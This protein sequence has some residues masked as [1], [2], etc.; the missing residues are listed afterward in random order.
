MTKRN[1]GLWHEADIKLRPLFGRYGVESGHHP[2]IVSISAYDPRQTFRARVSID[3]R[4]RLIG[5]VAESPA[6]EAGFG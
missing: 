6:V 4:E 3:R 1:V 5:E 2:L